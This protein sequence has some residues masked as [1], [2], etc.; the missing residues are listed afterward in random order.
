VLLELESRE[1]LNL[2]TFNSSVFVH[3]ELVKVGPIHVRFKV[4]DDL[5][6]DWS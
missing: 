1:S 4:I 6:H 5:R 2:A 3:I